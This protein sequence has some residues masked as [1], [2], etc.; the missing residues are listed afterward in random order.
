MGALRTAQDESVGEISAWLG[1]H[2][3]LRAPSAASE[4]H[5]L[6]Y[7]AGGQLVNL[8]CANALLIVA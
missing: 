4:Q 3:D 1:L 8:F 7:R 6:H 5:P 2:A